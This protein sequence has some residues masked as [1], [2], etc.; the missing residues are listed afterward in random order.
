MARTI[1][2]KWATAKALQPTEVLLAVACWWLI[3]AS[4]LVIALFASRRI[5]RRLG[6]NQGAVV[7]SPGNTPEQLDRAV[8]I[9]R[10]IRIAERYAPFRANCYPQALAAAGLCRCFGVPHAVLLGARFAATNSVRAG[11]LEGHAWVSSGTLTLCGGRQSPQLFA[12]V[13]CF[14]HLPRS[15]RRSAVS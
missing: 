5:L 9:A 13:A 14:V 4:S 1:A 10:A 11:G 3:G 2:R 15:K 6:A 7:V 8:R 12:T